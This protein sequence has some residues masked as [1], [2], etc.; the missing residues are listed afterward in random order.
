MPYCKHLTK[1]RK[2]CLRKTA[3]FD[4]FDAWNFVKLE[5]VLPF[6]KFETLEKAEGD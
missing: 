4:S 6:P 3:F 5:A 1:K 2:S